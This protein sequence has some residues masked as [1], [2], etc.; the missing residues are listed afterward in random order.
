MS[1]F[2]ISWPPGVQTQMQTTLDSIMSN[3]EG[4][5]C[6]LWFPP[7]LV[8]ISGV[9]GINPAQGS[10]ISQNVWAGGSPL[11]IHGQQNFNPYADDT[12]Y[13]EV[14]N[15]GIITMVIYPNPQRFKDIFPVGYRKEE[16]TIV[17]RGFVSDLPAVLNCI[18]MQTYIEAGTNHYQ[19]RLAGEPVM[20]GTIIPT[21]YFY[22]LWNRV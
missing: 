20:P 18:K 14:E 10:E 7:T 6:I 16:G 17:S 9:A 11:P 12:N 1:R 2:N 21:R 5:N 22:T 15:T 3:I 8:P 19:Y 4:R 13:M